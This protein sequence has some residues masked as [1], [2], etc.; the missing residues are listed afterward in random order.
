MKIQKF[1][2]LFT[3]HCSLVTV[4]GCGYTLQGRQAL[5]FD[6]I[7]IGRIENKTHEPKLEDR[8]QRALADELIR[9]GIMISKDSGYVISGVIRSFELKPLSEKEDLAAEYEVV[10]TGEFFLTSPEEKV[11]P[12]R[13]SGAFITSF[14]GTGTIGEIMASKELAIEN[15]LK[16]LS[17]E[18]R[19]GMIYR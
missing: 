14:F 9:N 11:T 19:A 13:N 3:I 12:L 4:F 15:A 16:N 6:S 1:I 2:L 8:L 5:P 7:R 10:I 17:S 18:I